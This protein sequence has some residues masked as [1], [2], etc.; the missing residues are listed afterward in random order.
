ME[1][2]IPNEVYDSL[3]NHSKR[4]WIK[5]LFY[6]IRHKEGHISKIKD[7]KKKNFKLSQENIEFWKSNDLVSNDLKSFQEKVVLLK[8]EK[9]ELQVMCTD[10]EKLVFNFEKEKRIQIKFLAHKNHHLTK[11]ESVL[12]CSIKKGVIKIS[13]LNRLTIKVRLLLLAIII[14]K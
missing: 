13:L 6:Y 9:D 12:I 8:K 7:L 3:H 10:L 2:D 4:K 1:Y 11:N 14:A 5:V